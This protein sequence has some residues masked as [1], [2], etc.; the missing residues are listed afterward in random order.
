MILVWM[1]NLLIIHQSCQTI[2]LLSFF[3]MQYLRILSAFA[4]EL[5]L[6]HKLY[7]NYIKIRID[8]F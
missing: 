6:I 7:I 5:V 3:A 1:E 8:N 4:G 2:P